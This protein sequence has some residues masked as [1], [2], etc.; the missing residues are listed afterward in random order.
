MTAVVVILGTAMM[1]T[2]FVLGRRLI[3]TRDTRPKTLSDLYPYGSAFL[4]GF[5]ATAALIQIGGS[6]SIA[7]GSAGTLGLIVA[8]FALTTGWL[9]NIPPVELGK[10]LL[11]SVLGLVALIPALSSVTA[12]TICGVESNIPLRISVIALFLA[13][14]VLCGGF[15]FY[16][17]PKRYS[18]VSSVGLSWFGASEIVLF[19]ASPV[20][21]AGGPGPEIAGIVGAVALGVIIGFTPEHGLLTVGVGLACVF[22]WTSATGTTLDCQHVDSLGSVTVFTTYAVVFGLGRFVIGKVRT[23]RVSR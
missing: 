17:R 21:L 1:V 19:L 11:Y 20:G 18:A 7:V 9:Q 12:P 4:A 13:L 2:Y 6:G 16:L 15:S 3:D 22:L 8:V 10:D 14:A 5:V 23:G